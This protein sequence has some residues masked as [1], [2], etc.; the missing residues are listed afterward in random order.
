MNYFFFLVVDDG[1]FYQT[2]PDGY[3]EL[4]DFSA[5]TNLVRLAENFQI[6]IV[7]A[8]TT[9]FLDI[10]GV[11]ESPRPHKD[12]FQLITLLENHSDCITIADHGYDH[13]F[14]NSYCE[15]YDYKDSRRRPVVEQER[16]IDQCM[17]IYKSLGWPAPQLFVAPAHGWE[18][19][20]TDR[21]L[22]ERGFRYLTSFLWFKNTITKST[23]ILGLGWKQFFAPQMEYPQ[24]SPYLKILP[25]LG[26]GI[27][28]KSTYVQPLE[29]LRAYH[30]VVPT[31]FIQ[32]MLLHRRIVDQ[33]H[34][35]AAHIANFVGDTNYRHWCELLEHI[36]TNKASLAKTFAES[37]QLWQNHRLDKVWKAKTEESGRG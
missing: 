30:S 34:N 21:L 11:S 19:G 16:H 36:A 8:C 27:S 2:W 13:K 29:W 28:S 37:I 35:Y 33:P 4:I 14:G 23:D 7:L 9:Q 22:A 25:R 1:G 10:Q 6:Q 31:G 26:T 32:S 12:T 5:Y 18:P 3:G 24:T 20:V 17:A 15:Y